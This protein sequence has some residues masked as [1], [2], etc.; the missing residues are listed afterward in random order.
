MPNN[1]LYI[2]CLFWTF[3][4][5]KNVELDYTIT[6][7]G[8]WFS[9]LKRLIPTQIFTGNVFCFTFTPYHKIRNIIKKTF[10]FL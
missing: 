2:R 9:V 3:S 1:V 4:I 7:G 6:W 5:E 8:D 10:V